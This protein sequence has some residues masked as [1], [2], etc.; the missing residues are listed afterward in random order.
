M[1]KERGNEAKHGEL[2]GPLTQVLSKV[3]IAHILSNAHI[4]ADE[5][6]RVCGR[7]GSKSVHST[8]FDGETTGNR[9]LG[10]PGHRWKEIKIDVKETRRRGG[11]VQ[12]G[13]IYIMGKQQPL[14]STRAG[15]MGVSGGQLT[16]TPSCNGH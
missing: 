13:S 14:V 12:T 15:L 1:E 10:R 5:M 4:K 2:S 9:Q 3:C 8:G 11:V 16:R 7:S 6:G